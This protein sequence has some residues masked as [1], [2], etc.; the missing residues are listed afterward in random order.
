MLEMDW[1]HHPQTS[2]EHYTTSLILESR[3]KG[4]E[5][6]EKHVAPNSGSR[7]QRNWIYLET[8]GEIGSGPVCLAESCWRPEAD[9]YFIFRVDI[10]AGT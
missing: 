3:G 5:T 9:S 1:S 4:K 2:R 8:A 7:R 10:A 6:T